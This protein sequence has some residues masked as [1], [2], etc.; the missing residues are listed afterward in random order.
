MSSDESRA[1]AA[2]GKL[3]KKKVEEKIDPNLKKKYS[4]RLRGLALDHKEM[5][6]GGKLL[7]DVSKGKFKYKINDNLD[8]EADA[9]KKKI[10]LN[11]NKKF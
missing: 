5:V 8:I 1:K 10:K 11:Y 6:L 7:H 4:K 9:K 3:A 2:I